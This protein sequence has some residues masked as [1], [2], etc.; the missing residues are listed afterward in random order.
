VTRGYGVTTRVTP[1]NDTAVRDVGWLEAVVRH[2]IAHAV[3]NVV[4]ARG[5]YALGDW[6]SGDDFDTWANQMGSPWT[7]NDGST[8]SDEDKRAI[9]DAII[10]AKGTAWPRITR[11]TAT[12]ARACP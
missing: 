7:T 9:K 2:E 12:G 5:F 8:I 10:A 1:D 3:D 6:W 11:S 4:G